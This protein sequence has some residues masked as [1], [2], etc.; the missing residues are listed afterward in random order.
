[1]PVSA[2]VNIV[3]VFDFTNNLF[4]Q[5]FDRNKTVYATIFIDHQGHM[6]AFCLHFG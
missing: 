3:F 1:M 6:A 4:N 5:I 2:F